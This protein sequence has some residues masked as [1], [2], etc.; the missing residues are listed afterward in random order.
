MVTF[1]SAVQSRYD[2]SVGEVR[3]FCVLVAAEGWGGTGPGA[4]AQGE[5]GVLH[6][7]SAH[8]EGDLA[9]CQAPEGVQKRGINPLWVVQAGDS[10]ASAQREAPHPS[11]IQCECCDFFARFSVSVVISVP[12]S[13]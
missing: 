3:A 2:A 9:Q 4:C 12:D 11:Q 1:H 5:G 8:D 7:E 6:A 10:Y 13:V